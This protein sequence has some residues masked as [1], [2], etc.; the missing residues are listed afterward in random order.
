MAI[1][2]GRP[3]QFGRGLDG[4]VAR[5]AGSTLARCG[6]GETSNRPAMADAPRIARTGPAFA[7]SGAPEPEP[8]LGRIKNPVRWVV[9]VVGVFGLA[10][11]VVVV[12]RSSWWLVVVGRWWSWWGLVVVVGGA[13]CGGGR[14]RTLIRGSWSWRLGG[15][16]VGAAVVVVVGACVRSV[17]VG[18]R[19]SLV[20]AVVVVVVGERGGVVCAA[21]GRR[22][23]RMPSVGGRQKT[24]FIGRRGQ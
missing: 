17:G 6:S 2:R 18:G 19:R 9:V 13:G 24:S 14:G 3:R 4:S 12:V 8:V 7:S 10:F 1:G 5:A 16:V 22:G 11:V 15:G 20:G 21:G 23:G